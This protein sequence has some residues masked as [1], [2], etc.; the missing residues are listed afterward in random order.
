MFSGGYG[1]VHKA[2]FFVPVYSSQIA[3]KKLR[4]AGTRTQRLRVAAVGP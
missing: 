3:V 1:D 4:P 2:V